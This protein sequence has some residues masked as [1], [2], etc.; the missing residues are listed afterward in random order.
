MVGGIICGAA[1][2]R[3]FVPGYCFLIMSVLACVSAA[4]GKRYL[5]F[6]RCAWGWSSVIGDELTVL[7]A[8]LWRSLMRR[9]CLVLFFGGYG[10]LSGYGA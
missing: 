5:A 9:L 4:F 8:L 10:W 3:L 7:C 1:V 6:G 2:G